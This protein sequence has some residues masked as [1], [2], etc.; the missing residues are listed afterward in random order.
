MRVIWLLP[1]VGPEAPGRKLRGFLLS[2]F[3]GEVPAL[4]VSVS[5]TSSPK[6][7]ESPRPRYAAGGDRRSTN[8][9][10]R[11]PDRS[12]YTI[13][14]SSRPEHPAEVGIKN[15]QAVLVHM[16]LREGGDS[17]LRVKPSVRGQPITGDDRDCNTGCQLRARQCQRHRCGQSAEARNQVLSSTSRTRSLA[18]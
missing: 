17:S 16:V 10:V 3:V 6:V 9:G 2:A 12:A 5:P 13:L 8:H 7:N 15:L 1:A 4:Q 11:R 18:P 14:P